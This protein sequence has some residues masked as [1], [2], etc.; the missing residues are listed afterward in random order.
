MNFLHKSLLKQ[1]IN[2]TNSSGTTSSKYLL[3][4]FGTKILSNNQCKEKCGVVLSISSKKTDFIVPSRFKSSSSSKNSNF[5]VRIQFINA[6]IEIH[7]LHGL[8]LF[9]VD[10]V[11]ISSSYNRVR[12]SFMAFYG[13]IK[14]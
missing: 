10:Y 13:K 4:S 9:L 14:K 2:F 3:R 1:A 6:L 11:E 7:N 8:T 5:I 12:H